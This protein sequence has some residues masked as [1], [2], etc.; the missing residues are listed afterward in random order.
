MPSEVGTALGEVAPSVV[1]D[2]N[3]CPGSE[4]LAH[5]TLSIRSSSSGSDRYSELQWRLRG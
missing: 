3:D 2:R 5:P 4:S 1:V